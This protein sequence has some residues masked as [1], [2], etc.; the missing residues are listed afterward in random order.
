MVCFGV[1]FSVSPSSVFITLSLLFCY[2]VLSFGGTTWFSLNGINIVTQNDR[3]CFIISR[4]TFNFMCNSQIPYVFSF[5]SACF[6]RPRG[7]LSCSQNKISFKL[8]DLNALQEY[9]ALSG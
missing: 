7:R 3:T 8:Q 1:S 2:H 9:S 4:Q 6:N 5:N